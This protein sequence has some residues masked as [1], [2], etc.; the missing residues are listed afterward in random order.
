M[1]KDV[2]SLLWIRRPCRMMEKVYRFYR[3]CVNSPGV[4]SAKLQNIGQ[5]GGCIL[6]RE[7][8]SF[9]EKQPNSGA[10]PGHQLP[11]QFLALGRIA[12]HQLQNG[13]GREGAQSSRIRR[14]ATQPHRAETGIVAVVKADDRQ[15]GRASCRERV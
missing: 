11:G 12:P 10:F 6:C 4:I 2:V 14:E 9:C 3:G 5:I 13:L 8:T 15:I 1:N 7:Q